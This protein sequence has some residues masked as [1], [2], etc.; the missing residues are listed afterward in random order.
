MRL[1]LPPD[2]IREELA[3]IQKTLTQLVELANDIPGVEQPAHEAHVGE[4][5]TEFCGTLVFAAGKCENLART[6]A[7]PAGG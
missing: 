1:P 5:M 3:A 4:W 2:A 6:L 7:E